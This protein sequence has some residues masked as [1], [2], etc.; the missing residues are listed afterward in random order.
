MNKKEWLEQM[1]DSE[2]LNYA[3]EVYKD[4]LPEEIKVDESGNLLNR[5]VA[6]ELVDE[7]ISE[8]G[9][10]LADKKVV[11]D[12]T[13]SRSTSVTYRTEIDLVEIRENN[14]TTIMDMSDEELISNIED[15]PDE[16]IEDLFDGEIV[17]DKSKDMGIW[18]EVTV[19]IG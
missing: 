5:G 8:Y 6:I 19:E 2:L 3:L 1:D 17:Y 9:F 11:V 10:G 16:Y 15:N 14:N 4:D 18:D 7:N 13:E 12:R